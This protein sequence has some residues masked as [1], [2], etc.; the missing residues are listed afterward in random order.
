V[1]ISRLVGV[2]YWLLGNAESVYRYFGDFRLLADMTLRFPLTILLLG[3]FAQAY[4]CKC[5]GPGTVQESLKS[6]DAVFRG[7]VIRMELVSFAETIRADKRN[8]IRDRLS[9][10][11]DIKDLFDHKGIVKIQLRLTENF[12][13]EVTAD[14]LTI[15]TTY[16]GAS[17]GFNFELGKE[18]IV[19]GAMIGHVDGFYLNEQERSLRLESKNIFWTHRCT[20]TTLYNKQ[21]ADELGAI[22]HRQAN[23]F[24]LKDIKFRGLEFST[25]KERIIQLF[26]Q[27]KRVEP[28]YECGFFT[29]DQEGGPFYQLVYSGFNFIGSDKEKRFY[30]ENVEFDTEGSVKLEYLEKELT[31]KTSQ[32]EF[33]K[34]FGE[35]VKANF[36]KQGEHDTC[37]LYSKGSDDGAIFFFKDG[38]LVK[39]SYW[40]PC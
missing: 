34:I 3:L 19:Y 16:G 35:K 7:Q 9:K 29:N 11:A 17:C 5:V 4:A 25:S 38:L 23:D 15:Y 32:S 39:F 28:N 14:T 22:S 21:E 24:D 40:T 12:K 6:A 30:L 1:L 2:G 33:I 27:A 26:G 10:D 13:G 8:Q 31:G 20:R 37:L 18:Y 36:V